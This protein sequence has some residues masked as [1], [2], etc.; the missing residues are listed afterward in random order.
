MQEMDSFFA[1][2]EELANDSRP[3]EAGATRDQDRSALHFVISSGL[4]SAT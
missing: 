1:F 3:D 4:V 2:R